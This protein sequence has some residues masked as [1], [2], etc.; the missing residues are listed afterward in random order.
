VIAPYFDLVPTLLSCHSF[1][2]TSELLAALVGSNTINYY[3]RAKY[4]DK[5]SHKGGH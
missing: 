2:R 4:P 1:F 5:V 3:L